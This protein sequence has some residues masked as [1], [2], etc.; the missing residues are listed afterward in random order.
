MLTR[1][2]EN[3]STGDNLPWV[4]AYLESVGEVDDASRVVS[5]KKTAKGYLVL[6][7][8]FKGFIFSGSKTYDALS[9]AFPVW[10]QHKELPFAIFGIAEMSGKL[11]LAVDND[12]TVVPIFDKKGSVD[13]KSP[14]G[15]SPLPQMTS[16]PFLNNL[17]TPLTTESRAEEEQT[18]STRRK[19]SPL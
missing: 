7:E 10:K 5:I 18:P 15:D 3:D 2:V 8:D 14:L 19:K 17:I 11:S 9:V 1:L 4:N 6:C 16:N 12:F 13:F